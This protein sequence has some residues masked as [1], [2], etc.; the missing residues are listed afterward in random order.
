MSKIMHL[1]TLAAIVALGT[2]N[3]QQISVKIGVLTDM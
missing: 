1:P 2:A 3:A